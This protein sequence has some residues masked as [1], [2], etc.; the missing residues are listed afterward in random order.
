MLLNSEGSNARF[1]WTVLGFIL[2]G[3]VGYVDYLAGYEIEFNLFYLI[4]VIIVTWFNGLWLGLILA[5]FSPTALF[6]SRL[7]A[8]HSYSSHTYNILNFV[9]K[10]GVLSTFVYLVYTLRKYLS[11]IIELKR[12]DSLT[13]AANGRYFLELVQTEIERL[14]RYGHPFTMT[15]F[16]VD[17]FKAIND[18][19]GHLAGD[20]VLR[21]IVEH[22]QNILRK[23]DVVARLGGDEFAFLLPET[24]QDAARQVISKVR[25]TIMDEITKN[26]WNITLSIGVLTCEEGEHAADEIL[27]VAD[28]LMYA[29]K[30][31][32]KNAVR[33]SVLKN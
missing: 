22:A 7:F 15:Y 8:G 5:F 31:S 11:R 3:Y 28:E 1:L 6:V 21:S 26:G 33:Y 27:S 10:F 17:N 2:L 12:T 32:G 23:T 25:Q 14:R 30:K 19:F 18:Q 13:G 9:L 16:D 20:R 29:V 24:G 4:P